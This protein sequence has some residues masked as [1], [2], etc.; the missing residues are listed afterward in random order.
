VLPKAV[1]HRLPG[2]IDDGT[3]ADQ[4]VG[5]WKRRYGYRADGTMART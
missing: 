5:L 1:F 4:S 3:E 2:A